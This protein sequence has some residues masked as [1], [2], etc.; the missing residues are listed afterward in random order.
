MNVTADTLPAP[1]YSGALW[2]AFKS[3]GLLRE[4]WVG[5]VGALI[6]L[7]WVLV[8]IFAP[9]VSQAHAL[10][11]VSLVSTVRMWL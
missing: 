8:A 6:V 3:F 2:R 7:F 1:T 5:M 10:Q 11:L 4:S 9:S